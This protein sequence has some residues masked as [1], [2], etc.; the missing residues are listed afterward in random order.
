MAQGNLV[1]DVEAAV[2]AIKLKPYAPA[3]SFVSLG[4]QAVPNHEFSH[5]LALL[6]GVNRFL[7]VVTAAVSVILFESSPIS[8]MSIFLRLNRIR[9]RL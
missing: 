3:G 6:P 1:R 2:E 5:E 9:P 4:D 8:Q 7:L